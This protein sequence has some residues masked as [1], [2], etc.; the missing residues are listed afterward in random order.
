MPATP[1][2]EICL[3]FDTEFSVGGAFGD[4]DAKRPVG[5]EWVNCPAEG[6]DHG[7]PFIL[8]TLAEH[9][10]KATFFVEALNPAYFGDAP[11]GRVVARILAAGQDAELHL[12]PCWTAFADPD[13]KKAVRAKPPSDDCTSYDVDRYAGLIATG[14][15]QFQ[16]WGAPQPVALRTGNLQVAEATYQAMAAVGLELASNVGLAIYRPKEAAL[17]LASGRHRFH[18]VTELPVLTYD[19]LAVGNWRKDRLFAITATSFGESVGLLWAAR[20][21]GISPVVIL[22]HPF[23]FIKYRPGSTS[24]RPNPVN[25]ARL[26]RLCAFIAAHPDDFV[27]QDFRGGAPGWLAAEEAPSVKIGASL[28][29]VLLRAVENKVNDLV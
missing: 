27:A 10:L 1:P 14:L 26:K 25:Q 21:A 15:A 13:W 20:R 12:H 4:P 3:T 2:T 24:F 6:R 23:E 19:Q 16:K 28:P 5:E 17:R 9:R 29:A 22:S 8:D 7:L 18:G 11:M